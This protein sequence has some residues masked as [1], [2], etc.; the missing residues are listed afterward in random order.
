[1]GRHRSTPTSRNRWWDLPLDTRR[2]V[3]C[4]VPKYAHGVRY[5]ALPGLHA[6]AAPVYMPGW[7]K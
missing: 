2:C 5:A 1:M 6:W 3:Q 7:S 4:G